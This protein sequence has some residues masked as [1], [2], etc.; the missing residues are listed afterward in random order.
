MKQSFLRYVGIIVAAIIVCV[1]SSNTSAA[2]RFMDNDSNYPVT[3]YHANHK[4]YVDL[5]SCNWN[6]TH[7]DYDVYSTGYIACV[8][9]TEGENQKYLTRSFRQ[10]KDGSEPPQFYNS[11]TQEWVTIP[12]YDLNK[13]QKYKQENGYIGYIE[14]YHAF[15]Y[16]MFKAVYKETRGKEYPDNLEGC[17]P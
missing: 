13:V 15:E 16:F 7:D 6:D 8:F 12:L 5:S 9:D 14:H 3:Y 2:V 17:I 11:N 4:E 1:G 10:V